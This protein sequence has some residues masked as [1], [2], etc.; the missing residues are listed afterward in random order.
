[1]S[2]GSGGSASATGG[3]S[4]TS[5]G[6]L[7]TFNTAEAR[8][9][10]SATNG[11]VLTTNSAVADGIEWATPVDI[12]PPTTTK[13]DIS[14]FS[15]TQ[16]R[17]P[18]GSNTQVLTADSAQAL[19]L[20]WATPTAGISAVVDDTTPQLGGNLDCNGNGIFL[21]GGNRIGFDGSGGFSY[22][23]E[24]STDQI[25][26]TI[27]GNT[28]LT[29][30]GTFGFNSVICG[31]LA[32]LPTNATD[33]FLYVPTSGGTPTGT[34]T[35]Y[36]GKVALEFDTGNNSLEIYSGTWRGVALAGFDIAKNGTNAP[37]LQLEKGYNA[38]LDNYDET[39]CPL[40]KD[41]MKPNQSL[42]LIG[43]TFKESGRLHAYAAHLKC[44][45][46]HENI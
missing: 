32:A 27:G 9:P 26:I 38:D 22:M 8:L 25:E 20:K 46:I 19:G 2:G 4:L 41:Q 39:L 28:G 13:G 17:I 23:Q 15:T 10:V 14:G 29:I 35:A 18:I 5:K 37:V 42:G 12:S 30:K 40:C 33:G 7:L 24:V 1:M 11:Q 21:D 31:H 6:D 43:D 34:P 45:L 44:L 36:T 16:A 3:L